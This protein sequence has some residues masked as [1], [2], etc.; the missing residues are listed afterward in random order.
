MPPGTA[1]VVPTWHL[2]GPHN[3]LVLQMTKPRPRE[4]GTCQ[5]LAARKWENRNCS[6]D[7]AESFFHYT[8]SLATPFIWVKKKIKK[9]GRCVG[10]TEKSEMW[11]RDITQLGHNFRG[12]QASWASPKKRGWG[13]QNLYVLPCLWL[14][15]SATWFSI[16]ILGNFVKINK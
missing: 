8:N 1:Q 11:E 14:L 10:E 15:L 7:L 13:L 2:S 6:P 9:I 12:H 4:A 16:V 3:A 5:A